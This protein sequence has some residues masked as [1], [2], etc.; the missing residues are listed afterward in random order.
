M[1]RLLIMLLIGLVLLLNGCKSP[2]YY[3]LHKIKG[4]VYD[5]DKNPIYVDFHS[6]NKLI[7]DS[8]KNLQIDT[9]LRALTLGKHGRN[10]LEY[11]LNTS[12]KVTI[13]ISDKVGIML[14]DGKYRVIAGM[15]WIED[16]SSKYLIINQKSQSFWSNH[17]NKDKYLYVCEEIRIEIFKGSIAYANDSNFVLNKSTV[18]LLNWSKKNVDSFTMDTILV[19]PFQFPELLYQNYKELYYFGGLHEIYHLRPENI[20]IQENGGDQEYD[21]IKLEMKAFKQR[22]K[23]NRKKIKSYHN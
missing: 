5:C 22:P 12:A 3:K 20:E 23:I 14:K 9:F 8:C 7:I 6:K 13:N 21:A 16:S 19:E 17:F 18:S 1:K 2:L 10:E 11:L 4:K 15:T